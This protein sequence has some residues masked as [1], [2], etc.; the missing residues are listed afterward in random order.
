MLDIENIVP[1][2][3][4]LKNPYYPIGRP[5]KYTKEQMIVPFH[6]EICGSELKYIYNKNHHMRTNRKCN[7]KRI[8]KETEENKKQQ[9]HA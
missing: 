3:P 1:G 7:M 8:E 5:R 4:K 6:C 9:E 2:T